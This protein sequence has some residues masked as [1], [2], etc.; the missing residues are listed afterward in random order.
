MSSSRTPRARVSRRSCARAAPNGGEWT[1]ERVGA[2][3]SYATGDASRDGGSGPTGP[4]GGR[5][6][7]GDVEPGVEFRE[8]TTKEVVPVKSAVTPIVNLDVFVERRRS[9]VGG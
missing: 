3:A 8:G 4:T 1:E 9:S 2:G 7:I 6:A 5:S